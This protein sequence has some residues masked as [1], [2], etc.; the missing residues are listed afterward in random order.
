M[1]WKKL[2]DRSPSEA[3]RVLGAWVILLCS[4]LIFVSAYVVTK[5]ILLSVGLG[6]SIFGLSV[7]ILSWT[8]NRKFK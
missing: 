8:L 5:M 6:L 3:T 4:I 1:W 2:E 7:S